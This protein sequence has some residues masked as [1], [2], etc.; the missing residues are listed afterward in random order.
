MGFRVLLSGIVISIVLAACGVQDAPGEQ[1]LAQTA[2]PDDPYPIATQPVASPTLEQTSEPTFLPKPTEHA[3]VAT[4]PAP[5]IVVRQTGHYTMTK[6]SIPVHIAVWS[7]DNKELLT[8]GAGQYMKP[9]AQGSA[10]RFNLADSTSITISENIFRG[11]AHG[12]H[13]ESY[14]EP[15]WLASGIRLSRP[16]EQGTPELVELNPHTSEHAERVLAELGTGTFHSHANGE[17]LALTDT[18]LHQPN[19]APQTVSLPTAPEVAWMTHFSDDLLVYAPNTTTIKLRT[20]ATGEEQIWTLDQLPVVETERADASIMKVALSPDSS[21]LAVAVVYRFI[22]KSDVFLIALQE[23][24]VQHI[25]RVPYSWVEILEWSPD[26]KLI[27]YTGDGGF[28]DYTV[29]KLYSPQ[30]HQ[31]VFTSTHDVLSLAWNVASNKI[32]TLSY[33]Q[34]YIRTYEVER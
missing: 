12:S 19:R 26:A 5:T 4:A 3:V 18:T 8:V 21:Y 16:N 10:F 13:V 25:E 15:E 29:W 22:Q 27:A 6:G 20:L 2:A 23:K 30:Q 17:V 9:L 24:T 14:Q 28:S 1:S 7:P 11:Y 33:G 32:A 31:I 34:E